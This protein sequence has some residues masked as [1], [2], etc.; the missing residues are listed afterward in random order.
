MHSD[1]YFQ[2]R[3]K[4]LCTGKMCN[5]RDYSKHPVTQLEQNT[6]N[7]FQVTITAMK[8]L[9]SEQKTAYAEA[10]A[11]QDKYATLRGY[12]FA[13]EYAKLAE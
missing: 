10:F 11:R 7:K 2:R 1:T 13:Q 4:T 3:G 8:A 6:R 5:P 9:T 12:I